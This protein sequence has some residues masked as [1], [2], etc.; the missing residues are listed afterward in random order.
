MYRGLLT[1]AS[2]VTPNKGE[3]EQLT[4]GQA[5]KHP[6]AINL[7]HTLLEK[8]S[9]NVYIKG[10][11][12]TSPDSSVITEYLVTADGEYVITKSK[13]VFTYSSK[14]EVSINDSAVKYG[15]KKDSIFKK[16]TNILKNSFQS[17]DSDMKPLELEA[18][19]LPCPP[20][21]GMLPLVVPVHLL[22]GCCP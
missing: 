16:T 4:L 3:L 17:L 10:G 2:V 15:S 9:C 18:Y 7:A 22:E 8:T 1:Q 11:H 13:Q 5:N 19:N 20:T 21:G 6:E 14:I 12:F